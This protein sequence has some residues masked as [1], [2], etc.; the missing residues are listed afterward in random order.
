MLANDL[1]SGYCGG[2][3]ICVQKNVCICVCLSECGGLGGGDH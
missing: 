1:P 2:E 3:D